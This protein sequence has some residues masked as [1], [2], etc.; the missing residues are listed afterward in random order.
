[1]VRG[2]DIEEIIPFPVWIIPFLFSKLFLDLLVKVRKRSFLVGAQDVGVIIE[3]C[4]ILTFTGGR[5]GS[6]EEL[7]LILTSDSSRVGVKV[8]L[9]LEKMKP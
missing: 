1:M 2:Q 6:V 7:T 5:V 9:C 4:S 8:G 3:L